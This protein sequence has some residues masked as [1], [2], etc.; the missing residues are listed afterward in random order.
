MVLHSTS[1]VAQKDKKIRKSFS[2]IIK[3]TDRS[4]SSIRKQI[5]KTIKISINIVRKV[6]D[7]IVIVT[8]NDFFLVDDAIN[9]LIKTNEQ[10]ATGSRLK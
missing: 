9:A 5:I 8:I 6:G 2:P 7:I 3:I 4:N 1:L 10:T